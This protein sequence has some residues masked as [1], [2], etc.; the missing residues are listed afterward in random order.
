MHDHRLSHTVLKLQ[1][2]ELWELFS[3][4]KWAAFEEVNKSSID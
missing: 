3:V 1:R 2:G 4:K